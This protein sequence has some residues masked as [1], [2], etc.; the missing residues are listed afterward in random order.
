MRGKISGDQHEIDQGVV[1]ARSRPLLC[2]PEK[3]KAFL[4]G[5]SLQVALLKANPYGDQN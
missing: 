4:L 5:E 3:Q 2:S 1:T